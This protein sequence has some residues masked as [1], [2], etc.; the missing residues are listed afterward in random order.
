MLEASG[1]AGLAVLA[2]RMTVDSAGKK[3]WCWATAPAKPKS[4]SPPAIRSPQ[5]LAPNCLWKSCGKLCLPHPAAYQTVTRDSPYAV[6]TF[7]AT[8]GPATRRRIPAVAQ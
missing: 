6:S 3:Q 8:T 2:F 7:S 1:M 5:V 4:A